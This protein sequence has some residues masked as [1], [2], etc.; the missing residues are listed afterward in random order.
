[1]ERVRILAR[2]F[3]TLVNSSIPQLHTTNGT[4][5]CMIPIELIKLW[6]ELSCNQAEMSSKGDTYMVCERWTL[7]NLSEGDFVV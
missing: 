6:A 2:R 7:E 3:G 4:D 1:M 5:W